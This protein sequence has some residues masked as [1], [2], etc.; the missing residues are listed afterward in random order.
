MGAI[1]KFVKA[2]IEAESPDKWLA[3]QRQQQDAFAS[4]WDRY[5][6]CGLVV[7]EIAHANSGFLK[8]M[9]PA[10]AKWLKPQI[11]QVKDM[12]TFDYVLNRH[13]AN[14]PQAD[15]AVLSKEVEQKIEQF[16]LLCDFIGV[17]VK[18]EEDTYKY[19]LSVGGSGFKLGHPMSNKIGRLFVNRFLDVSTNLYFNAFDL[20]YFDNSTYGGICD[21][22]TIKLYHE[23]QFLQ[24]ITRRDPLGN[25]GL[26]RLPFRVRADYSYLAVV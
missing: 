14:T 18:C 4:Y 2:V 25:I 10:E 22:A 20:R 5:W 12:N 19:Y 24:T 15:G 11:H 7:W 21:G 9:P 3:R 23:G 6:N 1:G 17:C 13:F 8:I 26:S 16:L